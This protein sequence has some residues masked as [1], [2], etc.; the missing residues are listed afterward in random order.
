MADFGL[1]AAWGVE[2][3]AWRTPGFVS[4][5]AGYQGGYSPNPLTAGELRRGTLSIDSHGVP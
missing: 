1:G 5:A 3:K 4:T 2:W